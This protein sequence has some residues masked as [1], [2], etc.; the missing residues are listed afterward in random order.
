ML[1]ANL[2]S[3]SKYLK[4][5]SIKFSVLFR[6]HLKKIIISLLGTLFDPSVDPG[7]QDAQLARE[8]VGGLR[9]PVLKIEKSVLI[10]K[11]WTDFVHLRV[12]FLI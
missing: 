5:L 2:G 4:K 11:K 9:C 10:L 12:D 1:L 7:F 8:N 6:K 3:Y